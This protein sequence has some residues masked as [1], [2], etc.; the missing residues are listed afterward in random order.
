[1]SDRDAALEAALERV[2]TAA[3][4]HLAAVIA[5]SGRG[6]DDQVWETYVELNNASYEYDEL[7]LETYDEVTPWETQP[8]D[9][10]DVDSLLEGE[11][12]SGAL[13]LTEQPITIAVRQRRDY[14][15]PSPAALL[16]V[17]ELARRSAVKAGEVSPERGPVTSVGEAVMELLATGDG[18]LGSL[19]L[20]E[21]EP[22]SGVVTVSQI[23]RTDHA[24]PNGRNSSAQRRGQEPSTAES[25]SDTAP[26]SEGVGEAADES[27][28]TSTERID[29][30]FVAAP[31]ERLLH[32]VEEHHYS[33]HV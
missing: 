27:P 20:P 14:V 17:A 30:G 22:I 8:L 7:L 6:D 26:D 10:A 19:D 28:R 32:R 23:D 33:E 5:S 21:L 13:D 31:G 25:E 18:A 1:M 16:R 29:A 3:R 15:I 12:T 4:A 2:I 9:P 11:L 24:H